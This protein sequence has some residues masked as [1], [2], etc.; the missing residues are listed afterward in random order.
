MTSTERDVLQEAIQELNDVA[1]VLYPIIILAA[2]QGG[3]HIVKTKSFT[4]WPRLLGEYQMVVASVAIN[5]AFNV[6]RQEWTKNTLRDHIRRCEAYYFT[7]LQDTDMDDECFNVLNEDI[8]TVRKGSANAV[9]DVHVFLTSYLTT[10]LHAADASSVTAFLVVLLSVLYVWYRRATDEGAKET[11]FEIP[12]NLKPIL[13]YAHRQLAPL[14]AQLRYSAELGHGG[15]IIAALRTLSDMAH[16]N[17]EERCS[18]R[19]RLQNAAEALLAVALVMGSAQLQPGTLQESRAEQSSGSQANRGPR[20]QQSLELSTSLLG[21][22]QELRSS[23]EVYQQTL[24]ALGAVRRLRA[25]SH[26]APAL[27]EAATLEEIEQFFEADAGDLFRLPLTTT[28]NIRVTHRF[29]CISGRSGAGKTTL[30]RLLR[31][32]AQVYFRGL[33]PSTESIAAKVRRS[34]CVLIDSSTPR[35]F[36]QLAIGDSVAL[37]LYPHEAHVI[38]AGDFSHEARELFNNLGLDFLEPDMPTRQLS[39]GQYMRLQIAVALLRRGLRVLMLD[40]MLSALDE[41]TLQQTCEVIANEALRRQLWLIYISHDANDVLR[42]SIERAGAVVQTID[43][44][45]YPSVPL[46]ALAHGLYAKAQR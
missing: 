7:A 30:M 42:T 26:R 3:L 8:Q 41:A 37:S 44:E 19:R 16:H 17:A 10:L 13:D 45:E 33:R 1:L 4:E 39:N 34:S 29:T 22:L 5:E 9:R 14:M 24:E 2:L 18:I 27:Q 36:R 23:E 43:V 31:Q 46:Y 20:L 40:E 28:L 25:A 21:L 12:P 6:F 15:A 32:D 35:I 38:E 11:D